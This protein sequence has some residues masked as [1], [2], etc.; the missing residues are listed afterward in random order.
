MFKYKIYIALNENT[1]KPINKFKDYLLAI[2]GGFTQYSTNGYYKMD[3]ITMIEKTMVFEVLTTYE[4]PM[5]KSD[6]KS[7]FY[8]CGEDS[9]LFSEEKL[10]NI[11][12][13][14]L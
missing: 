6:I 3:E 7:I 1:D 5:F 2:Y 10:N 12:F 4:K 9:I 8:N 14:I 11:E 13:I